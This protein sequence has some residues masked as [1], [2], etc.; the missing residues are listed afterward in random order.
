[1]M[2]ED[3]LGVGAG[4]DQLLLVELVEHDLL[5]RRGGITHRVGVRSRGEQHEEQQQGARA[6]E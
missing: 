1:M 5:V 4:L 3:L 2:L 6:A